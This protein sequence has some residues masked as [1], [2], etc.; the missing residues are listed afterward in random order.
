MDKNGEQFIAFLK[1]K[2]Q[3]SYTILS[4]TNDLTH[5]FTFLKKESISFSSS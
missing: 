2:N 1:S 4:Y 3:S 5:F